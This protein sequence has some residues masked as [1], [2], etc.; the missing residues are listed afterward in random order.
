MT[1]KLTDLECRAL[2]RLG[3]ARVVIV[4][5]VMLDVFVYGDSHRISPEAPV[6]VVS[7]SEERDCLGGAANVARN[8]KDLGAE[9]VLIGIVGKDQTA[10]RV[11]AA[12]D[13]AGISDRYLTVDPGRTTGIKTRVIARG[14]QLIRIDR[15]S[16]NPIDKETANVL[17]RALVESADASSAVIFSDYGKGVLGPRFLP[18]LVASVGN[19]F[20]CVDPFPLHGGAYKGVK[21]ITPNQDEARRMF[22][23]DDAHLAEGERL[24]AGLQAQLDV[25]EVYVTLGKEG[26]VYCDRGQQP[27]RFATRQRQVFDVSGAGDT[28]ISM[29]AALRGLGIDAATTCK[30]ANRAAGLVVEKIGTATVS[31]AEIL[32]DA[33]GD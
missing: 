17:R 23:A 9:P 7:V 15:E 24:A 14:Q 12:L 29:V 20:T 11:R 21:A 25:A 28:V 30:L 19:L 1:T 33:A 16:T 3:G 26:I 5:D 32:A 22:N 13:A 18:E 31:Q 4:G 10:E 6:P 27:L 2:D 8:I